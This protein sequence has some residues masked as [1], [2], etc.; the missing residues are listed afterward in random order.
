MWMKSIILEDQQDAVLS[1]LYLI[2]CQVTLHVS[3]VSSTHHQEYANCS[4][5]H[6]YRS[7]CKLQRYHLDESCGL[8]NWFKLLNCNFCVC[9][10]GFFSLDHNSR[11]NDTF[12][13]Y[14][15][16]CTSGCNCSL[17]TPDDGCR[18]HP[19]HVEWLGSKTNTD[20]LELHLVG[21]LN[22]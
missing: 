14:S 20:C 18:R 16:T 9:S 5:N 11:L 7:R 13:T 4:Y 21:L 8:E 2:Y 22:I 1:G 12:V 15:M 19:K 10:S 3:E 17:C 6:W